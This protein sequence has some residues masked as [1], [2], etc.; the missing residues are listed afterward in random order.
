MEKDETNIWNFLKELP[1]DFT[2]GVT[3]ATSEQ[4]KV[5]KENANRHGVKEGVIK[6]LMG[7]YKIA[8]KLD[9]E[10]ILGFHSCDDEILFEWWNEGVLWLGQRDF[11]T[12]RWVND[13]FCL[14]DAGDYSYSKKNEYDTLEE[15]VK[16]CIE[17]IKDLNNE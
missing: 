11:N 5:F 15:L 3:P 17:E 1:A 16:G 10:V 7:L 12:L 2:Y 14:G 13:K 8:N 9:F 6:E 4:L